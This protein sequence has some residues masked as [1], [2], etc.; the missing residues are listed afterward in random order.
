MTGNLRYKLFA[1]WL[2]PITLSFVKKIEGLENV[3]EGGF[4]IAANHESYIDPLIIKALFDR[5]FGRVAYYLT[6]KEA[7]SNRFKKVFFDAVGTIPVDRQ[8]HDAGALDEAVKKLK[9]GGIIGVFP[10]GTRSRDGKLHKGRTGAVRLAL[11]ANCPILPVGINDTFELWPPQKKLPMLKKE[12]VIKIG[13]PI[14]FNTNEEATKE[15]LRSLT[16]QVMMEISKLSGQKYAED[17]NK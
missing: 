10:E 9:S 7:Y 12:A 13:K 11:A 3:P 17:K 15:L 14:T 8:N 2:I 5:N 4:V 1:S 6:K 16:K